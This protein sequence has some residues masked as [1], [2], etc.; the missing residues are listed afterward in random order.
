MF[1]KNDVGRS[2]TWADVTG[3]AESGVRDYQSSVG[4]DIWTDYLRGGLATLAESSR[5]NYLIHISHILPKWP[6]W[7]LVAWPVGALSPLV[8]GH[9]SAVRFEPTRPANNLFFTYPPTGSARKIF[10][11]YIYIY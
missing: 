7:K 3:W 8:G 1:K 11:L 9:T 6:S 2:W 5:F 4:I 10:N